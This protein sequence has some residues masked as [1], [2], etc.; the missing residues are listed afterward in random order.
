M[1]RSNRVQLHL[2]LPYK[3]EPMSDA[4]V[5]KYLDQG[6]RIEHLQRLSD[7]E[8]LVTLRASAPDDAAPVTPSA[9]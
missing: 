6:Y 1:P 5:R 3:F 4:R 9:D 7:Q 8:A 2:V